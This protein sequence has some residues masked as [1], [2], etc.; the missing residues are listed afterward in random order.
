M[1]RKNTES[2]NPEVAKTK[3]GRM[4]LLSNCAVCHKPCC[5]I[6]F[7]LGDVIPQSRY[8]ISRY[9]LAIHRYYTISSSI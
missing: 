7:N 8:F 4:K 5:F 6:K 1:C 9:Y 2:E 3:N